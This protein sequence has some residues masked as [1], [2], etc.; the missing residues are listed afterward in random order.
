[1]S[2]FPEFTAYFRMSRGD[3]LKTWGNGEWVRTRRTIWSG[4]VSDEFEGQ[5]IIVELSSNLLLYDHAA[6]IQPHATNERVDLSGS[7]VVTE[8]V[9]SNGFLIAMR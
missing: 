4:M 8:C 3:V 2:L 6:Q 1:M 7:R 9:K 5:C